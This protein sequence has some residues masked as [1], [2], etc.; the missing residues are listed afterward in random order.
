MAG[1]Y[2]VANRITGRKRVRRNGSLIVAMLP[3][4]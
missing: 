1:C 2:I 3:G 4:P